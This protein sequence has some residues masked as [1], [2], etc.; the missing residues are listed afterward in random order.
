MLKSSVRSDD[1]FCNGMGS[2]G[3]KSGLGGD[4][5]FD[6][7]PYMMKVVRTVWTGGKA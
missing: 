2:D 6:G 5:I 1:P 4:S 3:H 7:T